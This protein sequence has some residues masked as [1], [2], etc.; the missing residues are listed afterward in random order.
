MI[1]VARRIAQFTSPH[2]RAYFRS[3]DLAPRLSPL[4]DYLRWNTSLPPRL[5]ELAI[6]ITGRHWTAQYEWVA[7]YPL[8]LKGGLDPKG[9]VDI[10]AHKRPDN[11]HDDEAPL[12]DLST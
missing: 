7:H 11:S 9:P 6:L 5:S 12:L 2:S 4:S 10:A 1:G 3:P 8:P